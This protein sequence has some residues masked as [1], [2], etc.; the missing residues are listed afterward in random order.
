MQFMSR[1]N[2]LA[3]AVS[4]PAMGAAAARPGGIRIETVEHSYEDFLYRTPYRFGGR[5]VD[6][7]TLLNV[8]CRV[9]S[10]DGRTAE[11]SGS[12]TMGLAWAWPQAAKAYDRGLDLMKQLAGH[13]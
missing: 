5:Q 10:R 2:F 1:R 13:I 12:M 9:R 11:G 8:R 4:I 3:G 7:V 6:R